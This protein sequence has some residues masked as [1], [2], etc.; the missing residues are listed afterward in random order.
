MSEST[1]NT[2]KEEQTFNQF[3]AISK[4]TSNS[5]LLNGIPLP[6]KHCSKI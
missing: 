5:N 2:E 1:M 6:I 3:K 4:N